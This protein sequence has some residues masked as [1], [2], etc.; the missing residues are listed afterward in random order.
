MFQEKKWHCQLEIKY[1]HK[2][3]FGVFW[4]DMDGPY[5]QKFLNGADSVLGA[6][7]TDVPFAHWEMI[8]KRLMF[9][10]LQQRAHLD[11][12]FFLGRVRS[13]DSTVSQSCPA[14]L[15]TVAAS[16]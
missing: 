2:I 1:N 4:E 10:G 9:P 5:T 7:D 6:N 16:P 12:G 13:S 3:P 11:P 14:V 15:P 8:N